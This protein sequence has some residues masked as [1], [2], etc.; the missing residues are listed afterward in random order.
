ME[1]VSISPAQCADIYV[2]PCNTW[3]TAA[4]S[5]ARDDFLR[6]ADLLSYVRRLTQKQVL[7]SQ[8]RRYVATGA[9]LTNFYDARNAERGQENLRGPYNSSRPLTSKKFL[10][11]QQQHRCLVVEIQHC[12]DHVQ[13]Q[14]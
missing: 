10:L 4:F 6:C 13:V 12:T 14:Q 5:G 3:Q 2:R 7:R 8:M 11:L 9:P 1:E